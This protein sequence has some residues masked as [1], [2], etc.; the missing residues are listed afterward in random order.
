VREGEAA[1]KKDDNAPD[2]ESRSEQSRSDEESQARDPYLDAQAAPPPRPVVTP[3]PTSPQPV[4]PT[5]GTD[6]MKKEE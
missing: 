5:E 4:A 2:E 6:P 1:A 3:L